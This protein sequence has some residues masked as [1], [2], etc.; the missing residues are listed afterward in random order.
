METLVK[1]LS[2]ITELAKSVA[3]LAWPVIVAVLIWRLFPLLRSLV[4][5]RAFTVKVAGM[6][7]SVQEASQQIQAQIDD[8][9]GKLSELRQQGNPSSV[10]SPTRRSTESRGVL[11]VDDVPTNNAFAVAQLRDR[12]HEVNQV[13]STSEALKFLAAESPTIA[14]VLSDM[15]REE[16][17][18]FNPEAGLDLLAEM[19]RAGYI[20]PFLVCTTG[21]AASHYDAILRA[22]GGD[23]ATNSLVEVFEFVK[24]AIGGREIASL[25]GQG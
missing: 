14:A 1:Y 3:E 24:R 2:N 17:G 7:I 25:A 8:L 4:E 19:R 20:Q 6:E 18:R 10:V 12:G 15:G 9:R 11:W 16:M 23:G 5:S 22:K 13:T 21:Q